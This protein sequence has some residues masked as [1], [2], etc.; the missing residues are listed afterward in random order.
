[1]RLGFPPN[2]VSE[3]GAMKYEMVDFLRERVAMLEEILANREDRLATREKTIQVV[4]NIAESRKR[5]LLHWQN[6]YL[7][8]KR[9]KRHMTIL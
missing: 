5:Q 3:G 7:N 4:E 8:L 1:M 2:Q 9:S 6:K